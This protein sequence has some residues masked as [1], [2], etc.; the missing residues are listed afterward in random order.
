[1]TPQKMMM[2]GLKTGSTRSQG[3]D[4]GKHIMDTNYLTEKQAAEILQ[5]SRSTLW[6]LRTHEGLPHLRIRDSIRYRPQELEQWLEERFKVHGN[7][8]HKELQQ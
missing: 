8:N 3:K 1:L 7:R 6:H 4:K 2:N 5:I